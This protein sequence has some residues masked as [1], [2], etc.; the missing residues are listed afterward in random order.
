MADLG[1][2]SGMFVQPKLGSGFGGERVA[3]AQQSSSSSTVTMR[4][5]AFQRN[6]Q[7]YGKVM[8]DYKVGK[9][10]FEYTRK[11]SPAGLLEYPPNPAWAGVYALTLCNKKPGI[12]SVLAKADEHIARMRQMQANAENGKVMIDYKVGKRPFEYTRKGSPAGLLEYPP[13]PAW[14]GVYALTLCNKK[15]GISR[16]M[17]KA[18]EHI[19]RMRQMQANAVNTPGGVYN[20]FGTYC[21]DGMSKGQAW[22]TRVEQRTAAYRE[23]LKSTATKKNQEYEARKSA[24]A[25]AGPTTY[26]EFF[27]AMP[28]VNKVVDSLPT[29]NPMDRINIMKRMTPQEYFDSFKQGA[30]LMQ[31]SKGDMLKYPF[32]PAYAGIYAISSCNKNPGIK[33]V[34]AKADEYIAEMRQMEANAASAPGGVYDTYGSYCQDGVAKGQAEEARVAQRTASYRECLK[35]TLT[36]K[37]QEY[38]ARKSAFAAAGPTTYAEIYSAM[39][40]VNKVQSALAIDSFKQGA[41][42]MQKSKGDMLKYPF[43]PAYAGIYAI[44]SCNKNPGIKQVM[45]KADEYIAEMR[46]MEA[47][48]ASAPGGVFD[49]YGSYCHDGIA[50]GQ[51]E[52]ARVAQ[53]TASYRECLKDTL[54]KKNQE[55]EARKSAFAAAGPTT[56][57]EIYSALPMVNK[58]M[59]SLPTQNS[60]DPMNVMKQTTPQEYYDIF[61]EAPNFIGKSTAGMLDYPVSPAYAGVYA[62]SSCNKNPGVKQVMAKA[63]EN[64]AEMRQME[65][66]GTIA[67]GGVYDTYGSGCQDAVTKGQ[68]EEARVAQLAAS[69][70]ESQKDTLTKKYQEFEARKSVF[71]AAGP[72]TYGEMYSSMPMVNK[73]QSALANASSTTADPQQ[74]YES[75]Q[76]S[77][78]AAGQALYDSYT[79]EDGQSYYEASGAAAA[80]P[81]TYGEMYSSMPM[82][83]K[84]QSALANASSTTA[85]SQEY[86][87]SFQKSAVEAGQAL[88]DSYTKEDGQS[89]YESF[90]GGM[91]VGKPTWSSTGVA[92]KATPPAPKAPAKEE[93]SD[94]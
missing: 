55:Y 78:V 6:Y 76:T 23:C 46:Q 3:G 42:L 56:Y 73:V 88:Y 45:A 26:T 75:F 7:S 54:T 41:N 60:S 58:V 30:N 63:D 44:S 33:Q 94:E 89:Y 66:Y 34:M 83:N 77:A 35:D 28:M 61:K 53:R 2:V 67:P 43:S 80:G 39:P 92:S 49:T 91:P 38:E 57:A 29:Q 25:A 52:E 69:Y 37:N 64:I 32:S 4:V 36:K 65:A 11:G 87:E 72:T 20:T 24:F 62:I 27:S 14:A 17:A 13:N 50:K 8:I 22:E 74:Y 48:A 51:A 16:L 81:T 1:F 18:D 59:E 31:K 47:N 68:A 12:S 86:Y 90:R 84:V 70:R 93:S 15:P 21:H 71:A 19:A 5:D 40:M 85:D 82:V 9:R 79:K 10:P